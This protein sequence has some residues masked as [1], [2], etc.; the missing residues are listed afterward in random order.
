MPMAIPPQMELVHLNTFPGLSSLPDS[1]TELGY[2]KDSEQ[3]KL[4]PAIMPNYVFD[5]ENVRPV[6]GHL[7][8]ST[9][10][11]LLLTGMPGSGKSSVINQLCAYLRR[12]VFRISGHSTLETEDT[13]GTKE[14]VDGDTVTMAGPLVQ[15]AQMPYAVFLFEEV[16]RAPSSVSVSLNPVLDGYDV[17]NT[18]ESGRHIKPQPGFRVMFTANTNGLGDTTGDF[19]T[20]NVLD[21][22]FLDR[23]W[24][25]ETRYPTPEMEFEILRQAVDPSIPDQQLH[26]SIAF[27]NDIR[28]LYDGKDNMASSEAQSLG[29]SGAIHTFVSTRTLLSF[30]EILSMFRNVDNPIHYALKMAITGKCEPQCAE[31]IE[32]ICNAQFAGGI[33]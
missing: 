11:G 4:A 6:Y 29:V 13:L 26:Q 19:N 32:Q 17:V 30:W 8:H 28:Y 1:I 27:A 23:V 3:A 21:T 22:S 33:G 18:L 24:C 16:D 15:A 12:P 31:A 9:P 10:H 5:P 25:W 7:S 2:K 20:A 14:I